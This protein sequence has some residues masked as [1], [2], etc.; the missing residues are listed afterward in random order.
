[1]GLVLVLFLTS[2]S[3]KQE[4]QKTDL[5]PFL[6]TWQTKDHSEGSVAKF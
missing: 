1:M 3:K 5:I 2:C 4:I 6:G